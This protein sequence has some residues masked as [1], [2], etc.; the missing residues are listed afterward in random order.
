[1]DIAQQKGHS[2][3]IYKT[4]LGEIGDYNYS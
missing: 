3:W 2:T 4:V 1:V